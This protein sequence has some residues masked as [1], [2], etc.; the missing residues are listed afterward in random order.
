[1]GSLLHIIDLGNLGMPHPPAILFVSLF[2]NTD[3]Q[4]HLCCINLSAVAYKISF[5]VLYCE[6]LYSRHT[7]LPVQ[8]GR[9]QATATSR[10]AVRP[11]SPPAP[12]DAGFKLAVVAAQLA[13]VSFAAAVQGAVLPSPPPE[14][15]AIGF[16]LA[17]AAAAATDVC[18]AHAVTAGGTRARWRA[19]AA[20][21]PGRLLRSMPR[22]VVCA[23]VGV[24][25]ACTQ[26][27]SVGKARD[28]K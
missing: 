12:A 11:S 10:D 22:L 16:K 19:A 13:D 6:S 4:L 23:L 1:M 17:E 26:K 8:P 9:A 28:I 25:V 2:C 5:Q 14:P 24:T 20:T 7:K 15:A 3:I 27:T 18:F 21:S